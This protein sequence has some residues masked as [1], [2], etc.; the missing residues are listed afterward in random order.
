MHRLVAA[1]V[2]AG[3][4]TAAV[5]VAAPAATIYGGQM[6][7][8]TGERLFDDTSILQYAAPRRIR[9]RIDGKV[10]G[11]GMGVNTI[12][13]RTERE[14]LHLTESYGGTAVMLPRPLTTAERRRYLG[15]LLWTDGDVLVAKPGNAR[16]ASGMSLTAV[17]KLLEAASAPTGERLYAPASAF[18]GR[19]EVLFGIPAKNADDAAYGKSVRVV[20]EQAAIGAVAT[21]PGAVAAVAW[22]AA[23]AAL[24]AG[25]VCQVPLDGHTATAASLRDRSYPASIQATFVVSRRSPF[26]ASWIRRWYLDEWVPS[27]KARKVLQTSRGR[28]RLLP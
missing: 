9:T 18:G 22:S 1:V 26:G 19:R 7:I 8:T 27:A 23:R 6:N 12:C 5:A 4:L 21:D 28:N 16:C 15:R 3:L 10:R 2:L 25:S 14:L 17:R 24:D 20:N 13:C 11:A